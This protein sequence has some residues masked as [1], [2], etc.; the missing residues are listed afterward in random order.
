MDWIQ[1][2]SKYL[3]AAIL[4]AVFVV[5]LVVSSQES[6]TMDEQAHIPSGYTYVRYQDMRLNPEHPPLLK[7]L[8]GIPLQFLNVNFPTDSPEWQ[9]GVNA[10]WVL[11]DK[12]L[13]ENNADAIT[14]W[15][16][17]PITLVALL[18]GFFI[19]LWTKELAGTVA[20]LFALVLYAFDPNILGHNH[21]VTTDIGIAASIFIATYYFVKFIK[22]P[23]WK[24]VVL[25]GIFLGVAQ[26]TKFSAVLLFPIFGLVVI[27]YGIF[28]KKQAMDDTLPGRYRAGKIWEY[29][30]KYAVAVIICFVLIWIVYFPN[31]W[32]M[33]AEKIQ[34]ISNQVFGDAGA[35]KIAKQVVTGMSTLPLL[36]G[37]SEYFL[38]VFMVFV[39]VTGGN[40]YYFFGTVTNHATAWYFPAVFFL[41]E[42]LPFL[43]L[44]IFTSAYSLYEIVRNILAR[45]ESWIKRIGLTIKEYL[46]TKVAYYSML[47]FV[48]LYWYLSIT[49]NLNIGFRHLFPV[50]PF[51][52]LLIA[53]KTFDFLAAIKT[54]NTKKLFQ[55]VLLVIVIWIILEPI[56]FFPS[57]ISY[58]NEAA[59]GPQ[60][61][62]KY[63]T[64]SNTDWGQDLKRLRNW[65]D[66]YNKK[67]KAKCSP[68]AACF[69]NLIDKIRIDYF[70]GSRPSYYFPQE[71]LPWHDKR[72]K[73]TGWYA[74]SA[75]FMQESIHRQKQPGE[76]SY[77]WLL[78]YEP[79]TRIGD[80]IFVYYI[81]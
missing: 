66:E 10:Q 73:E 61:G 3:V 36:K 7:D 41:K 40:T 38:G 65:V 49:G 19:Y 30:Y 74:L 22:V 39:R 24:N 2:K 33:P 23:S 69:P 71:F 68:P 48:A 5:S 42:T 53:K 31:T 60:S 32:N 34:D 79:V 4:T 25:A 20:G 58:F 28:K 59:G 21:Y 8:A 63:V 45:K 81:P 14:F 27:L 54:E 43:F 26:F 1:K 35:G 17:V 11:G 52:Y 46:E 67:E 78:D 44:L 9:S 47:I 64:D 76:K 29:I 18:L 16:R 56:I 77:E 62:Y 37:M 70:G 57:Y 15:S 72:D 51:M 55:K 75:G 13:H 80:S 50:L 12:F 6:T